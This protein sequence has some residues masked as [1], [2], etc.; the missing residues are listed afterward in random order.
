[1][2]NITGNTYPFI[3]TQFLSLK[4]MSI[5]ICIYLF[6]SM[7]NIYYMYNIYKLYMFSKLP[8]QRTWK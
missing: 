2:E 4:T 6:I 7:C 1:M 5:Y 8:S 3:I